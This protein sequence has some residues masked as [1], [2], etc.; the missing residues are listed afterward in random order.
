M[1]FIKPHAVLVPFPAQG[2]I[3]PMMQLAQ[4][5]VEDGF[6][7]TFVNTDFNH[8]R[9]FQANN[10]AKSGLSTD[11]VEICHNIRLVS[12]SD[13]LAPQDSRTDFAKL[14]NSMENCMGHSFH[15]L[16]EEINEKEQHNVTCLIVDINVACWSLDIAKQYHIPS[17]AICPASAATYATFYNIPNLVSAGLLPSNGVFKE[18]KMV[19][20]S[21]PSMPPIH[22]TRFA[23]MVGSEEDQEI[24]FHYTLR[25]IESVRDIESVICNTFLDLEATILNS[26]PEQDLVCPVGP[27]I[28]SQFFNG[29]I[30]Q[31]NT[32]LIATGFWA[33][34]LQCLEWLDKQ[35]PE[36]VIYVSFGS[37]V[38]L[39]E[40]QFEEFALGLEATQ[41]PFL[42]VVRNDLLDGTTTVFPSGFTERIKD[43]GCL[44]S[45]APQLSVLS[46]PSIAC[47]VTHC[48]WN[49]TLES[50]SM[51]VP[52]IC[53][54]YFADQ[55]LNCS[56]IAEVW[57]I[58]LVLKANNNGIMDKLEI[59][60][61]VERV[62]SDEDGVEIRKR[63]RKLKKS[64]RD[65]VKEGGSS[66]INYKSFLNATKNS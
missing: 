53:W 66:S 54:P 38:I 41:R 19:D 58:G 24:L 2:H 46:H 47:F 59:E 39:N 7:V 29:N 34:E 50:I 65:A 9:I 17:A 13:G 49:S 10:M 64:G 5:L 36:S 51:G 40:R 52:M 4:K 33:E 60:T 27:L 43:R 16:I 14:T 28:P 3:N 48:G 57:K 44:V 62:L 31:S 61:A 23:W 35:S 11:E 25:N 42:W 18:Q 12:I 22:C 26:F 15:K 21:L 37:L 45:W 30:S 8:A 56:Y 1:G 32:G 20:Y 55:F 63:V 6:I